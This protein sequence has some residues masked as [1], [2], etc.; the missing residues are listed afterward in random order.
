MAEWRTEVAEL[1]AE[2]VRRANY[3][4]YPRTQAEW[5]GVARRLSLNLRVVTA[6]SQV[7]AYLVDDVIVVQ[8]SPCRAV[9]C[10]RMAHEIAEYLLCTEWEPPYRYTSASD[11]I[12]ERHD[13]ARKVEQVVA[14]R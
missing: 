4:T 3:G 7:G 10:R 14:R 1:V 5:K 2:L 11:D 8:F 13:V 12:V 6:S 9:V